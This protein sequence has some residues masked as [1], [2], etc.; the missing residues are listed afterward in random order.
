MEFSSRHPDHEPDWHALAEAVELVHSLPY[1][2]EFDIFMREHRLRETTVISPPASFDGVCI[3][4]SMLANSNLGGIFD[5]SNITIRDFALAIDS[6]RDD[7]TAIH[8]QFSANGTPYYIKQQ[9]DMLL[10]SEADAPEMPGF[11]MEHSDI[12]HLLYAQL[13]V[14]CEDQSDTI[15]SILGYL[16]SAPSDIASL[17]D[18]ALAYGHALGKSTHR[19]SAA[20]DAPEHDAAFIVQLT[21]TETPYQS[22]LNNQLNIGYMTEDTLYEAGELSAFESAIPLTNEK[23]EESHHAATTV[24]DLTPPQFLDYIRLHKKL[25]VNDSPHGKYLPYPATDQET[26]IAY[27][28]LCQQLRTTIEPEL[29][30]IASR[31]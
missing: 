6:F 5:Q 11:P 15:E 13:A 12:K 10:L 28:E 22:E 19:I 31:N 18:I 30:E 9:G 1:T 7:T 21:Q 29:L 20:L 23:R 16:V 4:E 26:A 17:H 27:G 2:D 8:G 25:D 14:A 24:T 3:H